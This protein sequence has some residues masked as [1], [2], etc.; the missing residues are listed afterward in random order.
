M[1]DHLRL[2]VSAIFVPRLH[3]KDIIRNHKLVRR[4]QTSK[5][6]FSR[7]AFSLMYFC[8]SAVAFKR[9]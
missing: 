5:L 2:Y 1:Q 4:T 6:F 3:K 7:A 9:D 8:P